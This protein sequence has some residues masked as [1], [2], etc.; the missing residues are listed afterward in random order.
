MHAE[1]AQFEAT[2]EENHP[3]RFL[4]ILSFNGRQR[5]GYGIPASTAVNHR[6][7]SARSTQAGSADFRG[8]HIP[9]GVVVPDQIMRAPS[10]VGV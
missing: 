2:R 7:I 10:S 6:R 1:G 4:L 5:T 9:L 8:A 3:S